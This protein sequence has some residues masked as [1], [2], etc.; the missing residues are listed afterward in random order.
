MTKATTQLQPGLWPDW[1]AE[2][3]WLVSFLAQAEAEARNRGDTRCDHFHMELA[4]LGLGPP[5]SDWLDTLGLD[6][7]AIREDTVELLGM[8]AE[9][10]PGVNGD[11]AWLAR[12]QRARAARGSADPVTECPLASVDEVYTGELLE[13]ASAEAKRHGDSIDERHFLIGLAMLLFAGSPPTVGALR[14][15]TGLSSTEDTSYDV[16]IDDDREWMR[17]LAASHGADPAMFPYDIHGPR[18]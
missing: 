17:A 10:G 2:H 1:V 9:R 14:H 5:V 6:A 13:L 18:P 16:R 15:L 11:E 8:N 3:P 4:F 7:R 12:G